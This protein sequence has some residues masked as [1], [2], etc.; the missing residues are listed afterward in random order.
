MMSDS[1]QRGKR[2][3]APSWKLGRTRAIR[4]P[5]VLADAL[6]NLARRIDDGE[7]ELVN[8]HL[9]LTQQVSCMTDAQNDAEKETNEEQV[10]KRDLSAMLLEAQVIYANAQV[11][12]V[13][14]QNTLFHKINEKTEQSMGNESIE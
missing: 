14:V 13:E 6:L 1:S 9:T 2:G 5:I 8:A 4:V 11:R 3:P 10:E 7:E 12:F